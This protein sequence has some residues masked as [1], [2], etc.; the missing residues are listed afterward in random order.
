M[1]D[2]RRLEDD[3]RMVRVVDYLKRIVGFAVVR[4]SVATHSG[5]L[6]VFFTATE[7]ALKEAAVLSRKLNAHIN[8]GLDDEGGGG[9][10]FQ[11]GVGNSFEHRL[12]ALEEHFGGAGRTGD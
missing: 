4:T 2:D 5:F 12:A 8:V 1:D 9:V 7:A 3:P 11:M 6:Y 10:L